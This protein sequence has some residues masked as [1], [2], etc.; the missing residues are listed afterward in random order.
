MTDKVKVPKTL[1]ST[2]CTLF[3]W[4]WPSLPTPEASGQTCSLVT[5]MVY[6]VPMA[7]VG[8]DICFQFLQHDLMLPL[9][10]GALNSNSHCWPG[11]HWPPAV[12]KGAFADWT[13]PVCIPYQF[14]FVPLPPG[15]CSCALA[16]SRNCHVSRHTER[17]QWDLF[18]HDLEEPERSQNHHVAQCL[19]KEARFAVFCWL[20]K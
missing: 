15:C 19:K 12:C 4:F 5:D 3:G 8:E 9:I 14:N 18:S 13:R 11:G 6:S 7:L 1:S 20:M 16:I 17:S 2:L 10:F